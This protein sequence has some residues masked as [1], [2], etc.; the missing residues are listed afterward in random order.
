MP[1]LLHLS[2]SGF[3]N[4]KLLRALRAKQATP[5]LKLIT[6]PLNHKESFELWM[7]KW[8]PKGRMFTKLEI[9]LLRRDQPRLTRILSKMAWLMGAICISEDDW[10]VGDRQPIY[11]WDDLIEFVQREGNCA[12]PI[13]TEVIFSPHAII[14]IYDSERK[15]EGRIPPQAWEIC[16][17]HWSIIF[18][19]LI[20]TR[21]GLRLKQ[22]ADWISVDIW[23]GK[24]MRREVGSGKLYVEYHDL[25]ASRRS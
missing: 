23:T 5:N 25:Y 11:D 24:P 7:P 3:I 18:D 13:V 22:S 17:P 2:M 12:N 14:P 4:S 1:P 10:N 8:T 9:E 21:H 6:I 15:Q 20:P 19:D 16:P